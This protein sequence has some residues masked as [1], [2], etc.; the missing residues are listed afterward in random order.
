MTGDSI[1]K[2]MTILETGDSPAA[3]KFLKECTDPE[4]QAWYP[5]ATNT[6]VNRIRAGEYPIDVVNEIAREY[7]WRNG[8]SWEAFAFARDALDRRAWELGVRYTDEDNQPKQDFHSGSLEPEVTEDDLQINED[9]LDEI[10]G[11]KW[12]YSKI[13]PG[14]YEKAMG[15]ANVRKA[16]EAYYRQFM[17]RYGGSPDDVSVKNAAK[18]LVNHPKIEAHP[19]FVKSVLAKYK[20]QGSN[21]GVEESII[22]EAPEDEVRKFLHMA[23]AQ[24][25]MSGGKENINKKNYPVFVK[26]EKDL[27]DA[28]EDPKETPGGEEG[29]TDGE[30]SPSVEVSGLR[31]VSSKDEIN[32]LLSKLTDT[33]A[34]KSLSDDQ[35]HDLNLLLKAT[36]GLNT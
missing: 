29:Q 30:E 8:G 28:L 1:R 15:K 2:F 9:R 31:T 20:Q 14:Q 4:M 7:A 34:L 23:A 12:L 25:H 11:H 27:E 33:E 13:A 36:Q 16:G 6:M 18:F 26:G 35:R 21:L 24:I 5:A 22:T 10:L 3:K 32:S 19:D 17:N